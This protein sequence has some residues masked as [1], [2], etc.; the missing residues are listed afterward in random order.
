MR[1]E[2]RR[3]RFTPKAR[4]MSTRS[5]AEG[6]AFPSVVEVFVTNARE[7]AN[8]AGRSPDEEIRSKLAGLRELVGGYDFADVVAAYWRASEAGNDASKE[9]AIRWL[10][11]EFA[12]KTDAR[13]A[14]GVRT[15]VDDASIYDHWK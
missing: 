5:K 11:G 13:S 6:G 4:N 7:D 2:A 3:A 12:T 10:R 9:A 14:L 15:I 8:K 1:R